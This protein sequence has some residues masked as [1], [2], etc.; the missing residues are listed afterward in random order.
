MQLG[1]AWTHASIAMT[2]LVSHQHRKMG[3]NW[4]S[5]GLAMNRQAKCRS[6]V[7]EDMHLHLDKDLTGSKI[8]SYLSSRN[9]AHCVLLNGFANAKHLQTS[10]CRCKLSRNLACCTSCVGRPKECHTYE[11]VKDPRQIGEHSR[12]MVTFNHKKHRS[13][14]KSSIKY[15]NLNNPK[16]KP[17]SADWLTSLQHKV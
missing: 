14:Y 7:A 4:I 1:R 11:K 9:R 5:A 10:T 6:S 12:Y 8:W 15:Y 13:W 16:K 2:P 17:S 3:G